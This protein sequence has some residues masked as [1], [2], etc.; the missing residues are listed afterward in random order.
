MWV[1]NMDFSLPWSFTSRH[2]SKFLDHNTFN[3]LLF[4]YLCNLFLILQTKNWWF[5]KCSL[6]KAKKRSAVKPWVSACL[7]RGHQHADRIGSTDCGGTIRSH[8]PGATALEDQLVAGDGVLIVI[9]T[10]VRIQSLRA[11]PRG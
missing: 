11:K 8:A 7:V 2:T 3:H 1:Q 10:G 4:E 9:A 5:Q 6:P